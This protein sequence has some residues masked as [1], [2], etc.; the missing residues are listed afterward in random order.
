M[1]QGQRAL[2]CIPGL[3]EKLEVCVRARRAP[4]LAGCQPRVGLGKVRIHTHR[5]LEEID[6]RPEVRRCV[7]LVAVLTLEKKQIRFLVRTRLALV[8]S[9]LP[10][11]H[12]SGK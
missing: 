6:S 3:R 5:T 4:A 11:P 10:K 7:A 2:R 8:V 1:V 12:C 9:W